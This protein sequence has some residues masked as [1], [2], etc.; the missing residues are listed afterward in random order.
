MKSQP[1]VDNPIGAVQFFMQGSDQTTDEFNIRQTGLYLGLCLEEMA[2]QLEAL[3]AYSMATELVNYADRFKTGMMDFVIAENSKSPAIRE[4]LLDGSIDL[5]WVAFGAAFSQGARVHEAFEQVRA[6]N[7][8]KLSF[9]TTEGRYKT[10]RDANGKVMK[11]EGWKPP[12]H[13]NTINPL[14]ATGAVK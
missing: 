2:E 14:P 9:C 1:R 7:H 13:K 3:G 5:A 6:A 10:V 11:P 8:G 12:S 4:E